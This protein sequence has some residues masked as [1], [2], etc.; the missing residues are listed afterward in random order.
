[1]ATDLTPTTNVSQ[2]NRAALSLL[3]GG[4]LGMIIAMGIGRFVFTP[5][6]PLMQRDLGM[7]NT[8]AGW[9]ASLNYLGYLAG[10]VLCSFVPQLLRSQPVAIFSL[11]LSIGT[12]ACMGLA[13]SVF[14]WG[15][16]RCAGGVASALLFIIISA[17]VGEALIR[18]G[19]GHWIGAIYGGIGAGIALSGLTVP[20]LDLAG[21]WSGAW[22]GMGAM[23]AVLA[24]PGL[25][26]AK[27]AMARQGDSIP[28]AAQGAG[29][30][31]LWPLVAAYF[32]EGLGYIVTA[33]FLV[34]IVTMTPGLGPF[35]SYTWVA[36]GLA[37][38]PSTIFWPLL[39][40]RIGCKRALLAAYALQASG[41]LVSTQAD[42]VIEALFAAVTFGGTFLGIVALTLAEGNRRVKEDGK[43]AAAILTA[44]FGIGQITGPLLAG[45]I[46]D[47]RQGFALSLLLASGCVM[48]GW[49]L[50]VTD[51]YF[52]A[53]CQSK[54]GS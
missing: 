26:M 3:I 46:A 21:G 14:W 5:I 45:L 49:L 24:V 35:A 16:L 9:L 19:F 30:L 38:V 33:T 17:E 50:T 1:M 28:R 12:T 6:L 20:W 34:A 11:L 41:I 31:H 43:R 7:S 18:R 52:A 48:I 36:V 22:L 23:A 4:V 37:A 54:G 53:P 40:R 8:V 44:S 25:S 13:G 29:M 42:T 15:V 10:A 27:G 47:L 51:R 2:R 39:S 32:F